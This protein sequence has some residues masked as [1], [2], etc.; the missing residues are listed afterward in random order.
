MKTI[1]ILV[2]MQIISIFIL[3]SLSLSNASAWHARR[4][5]LLRGNGDKDASK[6]KMVKNIEIGHD[7]NDND[8]DNNNNE[9]DFEIK[10]IHLAFSD[11]IDTYIF[12]FTT[13]NKIFLNPKHIN[14]G[15]LLHEYGH[16]WQ[17]FLRK[18]NM[19][20]LNVG[21]DLIQKDKGFD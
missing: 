19:D 20:L 17:D 10:D 2:L 16:V 14:E 21:Y 6:N 18:N 7:N 4:N 1:S 9:Q 13:G 12:S 15:V 11:T 5:A 3:Q 8:D